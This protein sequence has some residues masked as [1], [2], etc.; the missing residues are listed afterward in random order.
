MTVTVHVEYQYCQHGKKAILTGND[1][2]TVA[3]N[4][5][6]AILA[7]LRLLHPQ[8]EGIKVLSV[9]EPAAQGSAP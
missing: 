4:T 9:T 8:W 5:T 7:M 1:S 6:R 2:L 3:E